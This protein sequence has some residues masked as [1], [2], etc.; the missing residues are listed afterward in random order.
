[1]DEEKIYVSPIVFNESLKNKRSVNFVVPG[2]PFAKQRPR[3]ARKGTFITIYTPV[4]TRNYEEKVRKEYNTIYKG[5]Q[6]DGPLTVNIDGI[7]SIPKHTSRKLRERM[8]N[9]EIPHIK[10]PDC[11]NMAKICLDALNGIA[12]PDDAIINQLNVTKKYGR[13]A[14][15]YIT[16]IGNK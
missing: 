1:M 2:E 11:D 3:A 8:L 4:E 9:G 13:E 16:I 5:I 10:K 7:F 14:G 15:I 12:Y 6:L